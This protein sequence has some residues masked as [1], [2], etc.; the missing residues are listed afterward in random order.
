M[1]IAIYS[2][3]TVKEVKHE[4]THTFPFLK[5]EF[6]RKKNT[7]GHGSP[8]WEEVNASSQLID[9]SGV[10]REGEIELKP[11]DTVKQVEQKFEN[12]YGLPVHIY[13]RHYGEWAETKVSDDLT[14]RE[15]NTIGRVISEPV[16]N[17]LGEKYFDWE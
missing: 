13:R 2:Q 3:K 7:S 11:T 8:V 6:F 12:E 15:Q 5:L 9:V 10:L 17:I 14:L 1:K 4:F 16:K